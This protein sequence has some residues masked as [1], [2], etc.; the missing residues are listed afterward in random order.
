MAFVTLPLAVFPS[1]AMI[2]S[3]PLVN[4]TTVAAGWPWIPFRWSCPNV[5]WWTRARCARWWWRRSPCFASAVAGRSAINAQLAAVTSNTF[6]IDLNLLRGL[7]RKKR[8]TRSKSHGNIR[9]DH[10]EP[11]PP[12]RTS[13][14]TGD[15]IRRRR[16]DWL[17]GVEPPQSGS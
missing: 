11:Q 8:R 6:L 2:V 3:T 7:V 15:E 10:P 9:C 12:G 1:L 17:A 5:L 13:A 4:D 16:L 14:A